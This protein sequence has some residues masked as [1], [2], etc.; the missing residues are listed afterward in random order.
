V[1][2]HLK[3]DF[4]SDVSCPWC[5]IGLTSL[6]AALARLRG[7]VDAELHFQPFELNPEMG[8]GGE[9]IIEHLAG[10]YG[11]TRE[12]LDSS[13][14]TI[15]ARGSELGFTFDMGKR[16]RIYNTFD[17]HRLLHWAHGEGKQAALKHAL[18]KAYFTDGRNVSDP[19]VLV[20]LASGVGLDATRAR[21]IL[22]GDEFAK[23]VRHRE[24][25]YVARGIHA[26]PTVI[27]NNRYV[28]QGGQPVEIFEQALR[29]M[30][31]QKS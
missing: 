9:S 17:A 2:A 30:A 13:Q 26:V 18:F 11:S 10:K 4:V 25:F 12:Q 28:L 22:D 1:T 5:A 24:H 29:Q 31:A 8:P 16:E 7:E 23:E 6:E 21:Q 27:I 19:E 20:E 3:I 15:R 14:E